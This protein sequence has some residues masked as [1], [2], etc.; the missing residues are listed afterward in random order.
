MVFLCN[1]IFFS[2]RIN[3]QPSSRLSPLRTIKL[4]LIIVSVSRVIK[5][6][7]DAV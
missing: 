2:Q 4:V 5:F 3:Y 7:K 6:V 1:T